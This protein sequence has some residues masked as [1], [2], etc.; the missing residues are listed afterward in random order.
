MRSLLSVLLLLPFSLRGAGDSLTVNEASEELLLD[1]R[2]AYYG[3]LMGA[4]PDS[5]ANEKLYE[6]VEEWLGAPY[7]Y[8]G[9]SKNGVDCSGFATVLYRLAYGI[10]LEGGAAD[11]YPKTEPVSKNELQEGDLVFFKIR[12]TRISHVGVYLANN[13]F[14]HASTQL[15]VI[16]SD[17]DEAYYK[18]Y[19][20]GGG[21]I[22][23]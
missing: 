23:R 9:K 6:T 15:G 1:Y 4:I 8:A 22:K 2:C 3:Q 13:K 11:I 12:K 19:Y 17:L 5:I 14:A 16:I 21:R 10:L 18:K 20:F 7:C